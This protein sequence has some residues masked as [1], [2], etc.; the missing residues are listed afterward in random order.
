MTEDLAAYATPA[1]ETDGG[2]ASPVQAAAV[3]VNVTARPAAL[4]GVRIPSRNENAR[5]LVVRVYEENPHLQRADLWAVT[6]YAELSWKFRRLS[7]LMERMGDAGLVRQDLEPRKLLSEL[8]ALSD[9]IL[10]HERD[11]GVT[12]SSR[13]A[14]GV[15]IGRMRRLTDDAASPVS[16]SDLLEMEERI[17][18]RL[19]DAHGATED[20]DRPALAAEA[21]SPG[22][23]DEASRDAARDARERDD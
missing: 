19:H 7:E 3:T 17:L 21:T 2:P 9:S 22:A 13:A 20:G 14:L 1:A 10:R 23:E 15:D 11:L 5:Q 4:V 16:E 6:R 18:A 12:A 8:R